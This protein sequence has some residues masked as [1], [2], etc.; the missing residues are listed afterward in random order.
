MIQEIENWLES[1]SRKTIDHDEVSKKFN[2]LYLGD[3]IHR[4]VFK[5]SGKREVIKL[6][7]TQHNRSE[8]MFWQAVKDSS[9][10]NLFAP[11]KSISKNAKVL[12]QQFIYRRIPARYDQDTSQWDSIRNELESLFGFLKR[13]VKNKSL[14]L[15]LHSDN[16]RITRSHEL[17][18]I[19]YSTF[20]WPI[21]MFADCDHEAIIAQTKELL[22]KFQRP[23]KFYMNQENKIILNLPNKIVKCEAIHG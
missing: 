18:I 22:R 7:H 15:D 4:H 2:L 3:G 12:T 21:P 23:I 16:V 14:I 5:E 19:D 17:K 20:L 11:C 6:C 1:I 13:I 8:Y 10:S 9:W